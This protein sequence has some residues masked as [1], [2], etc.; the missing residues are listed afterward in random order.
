[1][2]KKNRVPGS[3]AEIDTFFRS[4]ARGKQQCCRNFPFFVLCA[5][6]KNFGL[7]PCFFEFGIMVVK[8]RALYLFLYIRYYVKMGFCRDAGWRL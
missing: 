2:S 8:I 7:G 1:M 3:D 5:C 4:G 6:S